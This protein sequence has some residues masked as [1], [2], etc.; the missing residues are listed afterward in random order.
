MLNLFILLIICIFFFLRNNLLFFF[1]FFEIRLFPILFI[2]IGWGYQ[3]ERIQA[4]LFIAL[5]TVLFSLPLLI[6]FLIFFRNIFNNFFLNEPNVIGTIVKNC[7]LL[8]MFSKC[9]IF[10]FHMWLPKAHVEAPVL[11]SIILAAILLKLGGLGIFRMSF[12]FYFSVKYLLVFFLGSFCRIC[13]CC[14]QSDQKAIVAFSSINHITL[15]VLIFLQYRDRK[16]VV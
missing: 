14:F 8:A 11:G 10:F 12:L 1:I 9:P 3:V 5:Y 15:I 7:L 13:I 16:S 2:I 4:R 6:I